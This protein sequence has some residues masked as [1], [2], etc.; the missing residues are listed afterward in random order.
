[1]VFLFSEK[2]SARLTGDS[3]LGSAVTPVTLV[4]AEK[5]EFIKFTRQAGRAAG[6]G[7]GRRE[8]V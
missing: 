1:M 7:R 4:Y 2:R 6:G 5:V 3:M 8:S